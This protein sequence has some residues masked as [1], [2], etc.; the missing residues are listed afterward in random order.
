MHTDFQLRDNTTTEEENTTKEWQAAT[1]L[2][3][4]L[5]VQVQKQL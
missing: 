2:S 5:R 4:E 3:I 1:N